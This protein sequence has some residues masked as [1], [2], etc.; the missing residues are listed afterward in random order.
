MYHVYCT[1][2][3][4][5]FGDGSIGAGED[6]NLGQTN[7]EQDCAHL[8]KKTN[9]N[10]MGATLYGANNHC[11]AEYGTEIIRGGGHRHCFFPSKIQF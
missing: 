8:V 6:F 5:Q 1:L 2:E 9:P 3:I 10:A 11:Y 7:G 4:C